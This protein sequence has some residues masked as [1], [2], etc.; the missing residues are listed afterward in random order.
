MSHVCCIWMQS[1]PHPFVFISLPVSGQSSLREALCSQYKAETLTGENAV[2]CSSCDRKSSTR[3]QECITSLPQLLVLHLKRFTFDFDDGG[4]VVKL[5]N[6]ITFPR[7]LDMRPFTAAGLDVHDR[8]TG[9]AVKISDSQ[10]DSEDTVQNAVGNYELVG[11]LV[12]RGTAQ[13]G[14]YYS[15]A[16]DR[17]ECA[18]DE[19]C[20]RIGGS[21]KWF[22]FDDS[23]V[24]PFDPKELAQEAFGGSVKVVERSPTYPFA[25]VLTEKP[26]LHNALM[27]FYERRPLRDVGV[28]S[29]SSAGSCPAPR[30]IISPD[31]MAAAARSRTALIPV[32]RQID[33]SNH[34]SA[35]SFFSRDPALLRFLVTS[36]GGAIAH[37]LFESGI[38]TTLMV[39]DWNSTDDARLDAYYRSAS[40]PPDASVEFATA[41]RAARP[42]FV[43]PLADFV[44]AN[45]NAALLRVGEMAEFRVQSRVAEIAA[46]TS[47][48]TLDHGT[49]EEY[50]LGAP[51]SS[52]LG[53]GGIYL[54]SKASR[55][56]RRPT[57][58]FR[59]LSTVFLEVCRPTSPSQVFI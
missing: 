13:D 30:E 41:S 16:K 3:I 49:L 23:N 45:L 37:A 53:S 24:T 38:A 14:H 42:P 19:A 6:R 9:A 11:V 25:E 34:R 15:F 51:L 4:R 21:N 54:Q 28:K 43:P 40:S 52:L 57:P 55:E 18:C 39:T 48:S 2:F 44:N 31:V 1:T 20:T 58:L 35:L 47:S 26:V 12:H 36:A 17:G 32:A 10:G 5:N 27:L 22:R 56:R 46:R 7:H 8:A 50:T 59:L 29:E 33:E